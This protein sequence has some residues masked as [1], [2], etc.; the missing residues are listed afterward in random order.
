MLRTPVLLI[1]FNRPDHVR[2]VLTE[3]LKQNPQ[4]LYVC[5]D[6][7]REN[8][9]LNRVKCQEVR[10][11]VNELTSAYAISNKEFRL[12]T[13]YQEKNL[14][15]GPGPAAG[16]SWFFEH[17]EMGIIL[18]DDAVL[19]PDFF[20]YAST[21]LEK[22]KEDDT[23]RA[24]GS[25][26]VDTQKW[27]DGSYYF[28]MMNRNLCA[29]STWRRAWQAFDL[30]LMDVSDNGKVVWTSNPPENVT[31]GTLYIVGLAHQ[32]TFIRK[33]LFEQYGYYDESFRYNA[34][35][36]FWYRAIVEHNATT[37]KIDIITT[38]YNLDGISETQK[39]NPVF[40]EEHR[41]ILSKPMFQ[42]FLPDYIDYKRN[43][44]VANEYSWINQYKSLRWI[45]RKI[46]K[47]LKQL[48]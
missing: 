10:D 24:I 7:A 22:Y 45:L 31:F 32:S 38:D 14:G 47:S 20:E 39:N 18:E 37:Q 13:L 42:N 46:H 23:V 5:Q 30:R 12:H 2:Q 34:D 25:M 36:E 21:L 48:K 33:S 26:N 40:I 6:G 19:H 3:V 8:N 1:A 35:T 16:I 15:C 43:I 4:D 28:S 17:V 9:T 44:A 29:W 41:R 11:V 27:G